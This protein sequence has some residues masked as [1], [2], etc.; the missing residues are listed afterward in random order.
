MVTGANL[1]PGSAGVAVRLRYPGYHVILEF[2]SAGAYVPTVGHCTRSCFHP[3]R[4]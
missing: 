2:S 1:R 3:L 4:L